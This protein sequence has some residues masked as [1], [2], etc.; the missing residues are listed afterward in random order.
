MTKTT[1]RKVNFYQ[2]NM[3]KKFENQPKDSITTQLKGKHMFVK[4]IT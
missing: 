2:E 4:L 3:P 1:D